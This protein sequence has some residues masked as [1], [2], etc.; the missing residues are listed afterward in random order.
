MNV[1]NGIENLTQILPAQP[2]ATPAVTKNGGNPQ[3]GALA[4]D[5]A[6][7]SVAATQ[8]AQSS[9]ISDVRLDKVAS[10]QK[11]LQSGTYHVPAADVA[12]KLI[13]SLL[14]SGK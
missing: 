7:V 14:D 11:A 12:K 6:N 10:I 13:T 1:R 2:A 9:S 4:G 8:V 5:K 3:G